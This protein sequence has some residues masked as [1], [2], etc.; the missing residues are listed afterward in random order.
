VKKGKLSG[1]LVYLDVGHRERQKK[2]LG[3]ILK[4]PL[5]LI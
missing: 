5:V 3:K 4:M 1:V 2:R